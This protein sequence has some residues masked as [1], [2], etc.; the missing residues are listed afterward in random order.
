MAHDVAFF[1][2]VTDTSQPSAENSTTKRALKTLESAASV[3]ARFA[4]TG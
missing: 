2:R 1:V 3:V 4:I